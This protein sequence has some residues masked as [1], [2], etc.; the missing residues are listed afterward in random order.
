[1]GEGG[2]KRANV[3]KASGNQYTTDM[4]CDETPGGSFTCPWRSLLHA[5]C[6]ML[7]LLLVPSAWCQCSGRWVDGIGVP[8][9]DD[10]VYAMCLW[11]P[12]GGGPSPEKLV[13]GG[14]FTHAG[15]VAATGIASYDLENGQWSPLGTGVVEVRALT[16][17]SGGQLVAGGLFTNGTSSWYGVARWTGGAWSPLGTGS[18]DGAIVALTT[19]PNGDIVAG[20][21]FLNAPGTSASR[22]A[23]WNGTSWQRFGLGF[24]ANVVNDVVVLPN[25][26]LVACGDFV[27]AN[28]PSVDW[29]IVNRVA[30]WNGSIWVPLG[31]GMNNEVTSL[32]VLTDGSLVAGGY[33]TNAGGVNARRIARWNGTNWSRLL[34]GMNSEVLSL[35]ALPDGG[36]VSGGWFTSAAGV[37]ASHI[38]L[39]DGTAWAAM[40]TGVTGSNSTVDV[41]VV[42]PGGDVVAGGGFGRAGGVTANYLARYSFCDPDSDGDGLPDDWEINGI[43]YTD[44][45]GVARRYRLQDADPSRPPDPM[46]KDLYLEIDFVQG[47]TFHQEAINKVVAAFSAAP[48]ASVNNPDSLPG[49]NLHVVYDE[50]GLTP[51]GVW[52][53]QGEA[54]F[55]SIKT[56][57]FGT[58]YERSALG[59]EAVNAKKRAFRYCLYADELGDGR[60]GWGEGPGDAQCVLE[61]GNDMCIALGSAARLF[62][63]RPDLLV[64]HEAAVFMHELGHCLGLGHGGGDCVHFKPN[65]VSVMNYG[66]TYPYQ[67]LAGTWKLDYSAEESDAAQG[68]PDLDETAL[69]EAGFSS[70]VSSGRRFAFAT[71]SPSGARGYQTGVIGS[72]VDWNNDRSISPAS[73]TFPSDLNFFGMSAC[74]GADLTTI[75][76]PEVRVPTPSQ[77]MHSFDDWKLLKLAIGVT[78]NFADA[79]P[80]P[81]SGTEMSNAL[82]AQMN[83]VFPFCLADYNGS[84]SVSVQDIFDFLAGFFSGN[85]RADIN[86][87]GQVTVQDIFDFLQ[88]YFVGCN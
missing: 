12:D 79:P 14:R 33:F 84:G 76:I 24:V 86:Q 47:T 18:W 52:A 25:G 53:S 68:R 60:W 34:N 74:S 35:V 87:T 26:D 81:T 7:L 70:A 66:Q 59:V 58:F 50:T 19:L 30:R 6:P 57:H 49:I 27:D 1:M 45:G 56:G 71:V 78:G 40:G 51:G 46:H 54:E 23:R 39:W 42:L 44:A 77:R 29:Q 64:W 62:V 20:G 4:K 63:N 38:A 88:A 15:S 41:L 82:Y 73:I 5:L 67:W 65:Y 36:L 8:G 55:N 61:G 2:Q 37:S 17:T 31:T 10:G 28:Y 22:I 3:L 75:C 43:P 32:A 80:V 83:V 11:D 16:K 13:V 21:R 69:N 72:P 9:V 85:V 48:A